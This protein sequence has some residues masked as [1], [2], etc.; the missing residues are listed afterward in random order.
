MIIPSEIVPIDTLK[1]NG[2]NPNKMSKTVFSFLKQMI[3][4]NG[5]CQAVV[6]TSDYV[7]IDGEH[8][9]RAM[10]ELG[11][12]EIEVKVLPVTEDEA[13]LLTINFN[14]TKGSLTL[15]ELG[16]ILS[17]QEEKIGRERLKELIVLDQKRIDQAMGK[18]KSDEPIEE[19]DDEE[20]P[21]T[22]REVTY[23]QIFKLG[24]HRLMCGD[25]TNSEDVNRLM[26]GEV[27]TLVATDPPYNVGGT[28]QKPFYCGS[29][30][31]SHINLSEADWDKSFS[32]DKVLENIEDH[33][34]PNVTVYIFTSQYLAGKIWEWMN[35]WSDFYSY[36]VWCKPNPAPSLS[37]RYYTW[38]TEL[39]PFA[40]RGAHTFNYLSDGH[41]L[42]YFLINKGGKQTEHPTEKPVELFRHII[43]RSSNAREVVMDLFGGSG[44]CLIAC[45]QLGRKCYMMERDP[46]WVAEIIARWE[47][48][49][50]QEAVLI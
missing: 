20:L 36:T 27:A 42:S 22:R 23:G 25:S 10:K 49:T 24:N 48:L 44:T 18:F 15:R 31:V 12:T 38:A 34:S 5:F 7:I 2:Y 28:M 50:K 1:V 4:K 17:E 35:T 29:S 14:E 47:R 46:K 39:V 6:V 26:N 21:D 32:I 13:K 33:I 11:E 40:T 30:L 41:E 8:R 43:Q 37:K 9:W 3:E 45:E 16:K 19:E